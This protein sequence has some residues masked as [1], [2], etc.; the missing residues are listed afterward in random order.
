M[1][2]EKGKKKLYPWGKIQASE[3][4]MESRWRMTEGANSFS[5]RPCS[6]P[7]PPP[8]PPHGLPHP[9]DCRALI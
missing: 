9:Q 4:L 2:E 7:P 3:L 6:P 5:E 1:L 8:P